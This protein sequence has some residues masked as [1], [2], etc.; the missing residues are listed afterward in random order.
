M[1]NFKIQMIIQ[2][3]QVLVSFIPHHGLSITLSCYYTEQCYTE[4]KL[5]ALQ[6]RDL[7]L[8]NGTRTKDTVERQMIISSVRVR[9][10]TQLASCFSNHVP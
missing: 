7:C 2:R 4:F 3:K 5:P 8:E 1:Y 6:Q 9:I 10:Y